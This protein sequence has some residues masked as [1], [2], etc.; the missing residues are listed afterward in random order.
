MSSGSIDMYIGP[1]FAGKSTMLIRTANKYKSIGMKIMVINNK[2]DNRYG[3]NKI[4]THDQISIKS[5]MVDEL[6]E[7]LSN[8]EYFCEFKNSD[9]IIIEE[10]QFFNDIKFIIEASD[11]HNKKVIVS[12]LD[13]DFQRKPFESVINLIPYADNITKLKG[14]CKICR[15]GTP[16]IFSKRIVNDN[17]TLLIGGSETYESVCRKHYNN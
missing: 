4:I 8:Y 5:I 13:G 11:F 16:S 2:K 10:L 9:I 6:N 1:M 7:I 15:D 3:N 14:F 17:S 12:G